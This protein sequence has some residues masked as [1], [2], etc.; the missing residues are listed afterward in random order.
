M[1]QAEKDIATYNK[2]KSGRMNFDW[3]WQKVAD[4]TIPRRGDFVVTRYP[5]QR[6]DYNIYDSTA[7]WALD[8]FAAG[9]HW[10]LTSQSLPWFYLKLRNQWKSNS[11]AAQ[12]WLQDLE[13]RINAVFND[14]MSRFQ[15]QVHEFYLD[16]GA[17]GTAVMYVE[18]DN[19]VKF[20]TRFLGECYIRQTHYGIIDSLYRAFMLTK[21]E[22][23][24]MFGEANLG[25][26]IMRSTDPM[27]QFG[28]LHV[29]EPDG[30]IW[31]SRYISLEDNEVCKEGSYDSFPYMVARWEKTAYEDYGRSPAINCL[32]EIFTVNK[33]RMTLLRAQEK[34]VDP[35][36]LIPNDGFMQPL[37]LNPGMP[38][39][40]DTSMPGKIEYLESKGRFDVGGNSIKD[41]QAAITRAF[42]VD[43]FQLPGGMM[44]GA[45]HQNTYMTA[46]EAGFRRDSQ[47]RVIGPMSAR[48]QAEFL[49][50]LIM[51]VYSML[52]K[53]RSI[54]PPPPGIA[55]QGIDI[56]YV[57]P[58]AIAQKAA[59]GDNFLRAMQL[60]NPIGT[61]RPEV[62]DGF[63]LD[64]FPGYSAKIYRLPA[65]LVRTPEQLAQFRQQQAAAAAAQNGQG[66][67]SGPGATIQEDPN[68][69]NASRNTRAASTLDKASAQ[70]RA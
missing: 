32:S 34:A 40:Y 53:R 31:A 41:T 4:Y 18:D 63:N 28:F 1:N 54:P 61:V 33:Q 6:R 24:N 58:L 12:A 43:A 30:S 45:E 70:L 15:S 65:Q 50:P 56:E 62:Y 52:K 5:G 21:E 13:D 69:I 17:F 19:G 14:P 27:Q 22:A 64:E 51:R 46:T 68:L 66:Q 59:E 44:P 35:P 48:M 37:N 9:L 7:V 26:N 20:S 11:P 36:L 16:I 60:L 8:Q 57:S 55:G 25:K 29:V 38:N 39:Y 23:V 47:M 2:L 3:L 49:S 10:M 67:T 42:Y